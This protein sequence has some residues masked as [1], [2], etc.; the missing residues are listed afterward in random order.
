MS[1]VDRFLALKGRR[2]T[3]EDGNEYQLALLPAMSGADIAAFEERI[4]CPV[5]NDIRALLNVTRGVENGPLE[6]FDISGMM[7]GG[8]GLEEIFPTPLSIAHDGFGNYWVADL[9]PGSTAWGPIYFACHDAPVIVYQCASLSE[10]LD[11]FLE[12]AQPPYKGPLN[13]VHEEASSK[14]WAEEPNTFVRSAALVSEN[15]EL[16][17]FA[18]TLDDTWRLV[19][20]RNARMGDGFAWGRAGSPADIKRWKNLPLFAYRQKKSLWQRLFG[21]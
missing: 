15:P 12:M 1:L 20:L 4:P 9:L 5:P 17:S 6:S 10:F 13:F 19:D 11:A 2:F 21:K 3:D 8:F 16:R 7:E 14:I 18:E